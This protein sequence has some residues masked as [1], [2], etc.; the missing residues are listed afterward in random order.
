MK[1]KKILSVVLTLALVFSAAPL[2]GFVGLELPGLASLFETKAAAYGESGT[3][4]D[5]TWQWVTVSGR[6][7][8]LGFSGSGA[9]ADYASAADTP[10][11][12]YLNE[13]PFSSRILVSLSRQS[14]VTHIGD[15]AFAD[16][17]KPIS[18][19]GLPSSLTSIGDYAF[20]GSTLT[21]TL[22]IPT[23]VTSIGAWY[24]DASNPPAAIAVYY[25]GTPRDWAMI[26]MPAGTRAYLNQNLTTAASET[27]IWG[28]LY[29]EVGIDGEI[30]ITDCNTT[31]TS[32]VVPDEIDGL[33][34][35]AIDAGVFDFAGLQSVT[36][37][38]R[39]KTL[40][41]W[42]ADYSNAPA[43]SV[44]Y[45]NTLRAWEDVTKSQETHDYLQDVCNMTYAPNNIT[46]APL[47]Y[48]TERYET[49]E[50][51]ECASN[52]TG[53][54]SIPATVNGMPVTAIVERAFYDSLVTTVNIPAS[55]TEIDPFAGPDLIH[56][57]VDP[58]NPVYYSVNDC[59]VE[60]A[61]GKVVAGCTFSAL[62]DDGSISS[63]G[64]VA[65]YNLPD[66][67]LSV[68][69]D[70]VT[71]IEPGAFMQCTNLSYFYLPGSM[72][73][74]GDAAFALTSITDLYFPEN[75][76][77]IGDGVLYGDTALTEVV[78][79]VGVQSIG[80]W[81]DDYTNPEP[82]AIHVTYY[83]SASKWA[84]IQMSQATRDYLEQDITFLGYDAGDVIEY[85][86]YPQ[87]LVRDTNLINAL[88]EIDP[89]DGNWT[90]LGYYAAGPAGAMTPTDAMRYTDVTYQGEMYRGVIFNAY[91]DSNTWEDSGDNF[92]VPHELALNTVYWFKYEPLRWR[93]LDPNEGLVICESIIDVRAYND[94]L[95]MDRYWYYGDAAKTY[96]AS[97]YAESSIRAW[98]IDDF[99]NTAFNAAEQSNM[100]AA[101]L[102]NDCSMT[103]SGSDNF[104]EFDVPATNDKVF[105]LDFKTVNDGANSYLAGGGAV[106]HGTDYA[107]AQGLIYDENSLSSYWWLRTPGINDGQDASWVD[108]NGHADIYLTV[109]SACTG[110]RPVIKLEEIV[111]ERLDN[112]TYGP[113]TYS[114][115]LMSGLWV[116][117]CDPTYQGA[118]VIPT[119]ED[120]GVP[121]IGIDTGAFRNCTGV[122]SVTI[123][124]TV[125]VIG[126]NAFNSCYALQS[127]NIPASVSSFGESAFE[128]CIALSTV[129][130]ESGLRSIGRCAFM[131][132][133][134][135]TSLTIPASVTRI[136]D[137]AFAGTGLTAITL[138]S[139]LLSLGAAAFQNCRSL[140]GVTFECS[141]TLIDS[142]AFKNCTSLTAITLPD[143]LT[144]IGVQAF[145]GAG[146]TALTIPTG[147]ISI[148]EWYS[149]NTAPASIRVTYGGTQAQWDAITMSQKTRNYLGLIFNVINVFPLVYKGNAATGLTVIACSPVYSGALVVP[150]EPVAGMSV[151]AIGANA[152][153]DCAD[154]TRVTLPATV[155]EIGES[156][157]RNCTGMEEINIPAGVTEIGESA[158]RNCT[159]L[160]EI[161]IPAGVTVISEYAFMS[162]TEL[163]EITVPAG[164]ATIG[165]SAFWGCL[166]VTDLTIENGVGEIG[167]YAFYACSSLTDV[168]IPGSVLSV[169]NYAFAEC[170]NLESATFENGVVSLGS[171][172]FIY[173]FDLQTV[174]I[175]AS[176]TVI[177]EW[178]SEGGTVPSSITTVYG[179][180]QAQW[181]AITMSNRTRTY[182]QDL[183]TVTFVDQINHL[184][185]S[186]TA[187]VSVTLPEPD[188]DFI[189]ENMIFRGWST[190]ESG[191]TIYPIGETIRLDT[192]RTFY[193]K[194]V[195]YTLIGDNVPYNGGI[196]TLN[197]A[198]WLVVG[199]GESSWLLVSRDCLREPN[200]DMVSCNWDNAMSACDNVYTNSIAAVE[201]PLV[202]ATSKNADS[203]NYDGGMLCT[204]LELIDAHT[205]MLSAAEVDTYL[206]DETLPVLTE[207]KIWTRSSYQD[208]AL[209]GTNIF[210]EYTLRSQTDNGGVRP[211]LQLDRSMVLLTS[212]D[213][214]DSKVPAVDG[215]FHSFSVTP[216]VPQKLTIIRNEWRNFTASA[217]KSTVR[218]G[219]SLEITYG[220]NQPGTQVVISAMICDEEN[221]ILYYAST[222]KPTSS[223]TGGTWDLT[224][225]AELAAGNYTLKVFYERLIGSHGSDYASPAVELP[226]A[227]EPTIVVGG[228]SLT[229]DGDIGMNFYVDIPDVTANAYAEFTVAGETRTVP[230]NLSK[231]ITQNG[232]RLYK[233]SC[234]VHSVQTSMKIS[235]IFRNGDNSSGKILY[236]VNDYFDL[237][238]ATPSAQTNAKLMALMRSLAVYSYYANVQLEY[239]DDFIQS[240]LFDDSP[241]AS[242]DAA[243]IANYAEQVSDTANGVQWYG[244]SLVL[245][246]ETAIKL[247]FR[248]RSGQSIN[249]FTFTLSNGATS[250]VVT[251]EANGNLYVIEIPDIASGRLGTVYTVN[252][253]KNA[254]GSTV[255]TWSY[256]ALSY[257][258]KVLA[259]FESATP[260]VT[261]AQAN[262][263]KALVNYYNAAK[264]YFG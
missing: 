80:E 163:Q 81:L 172:I 103:L 213:C 210:G 253:T 130:M 236:A 118:I 65:F 42:R 190:A 132:C 245:R 66:L 119:A 195:Y 242:I 214:F 187:F 143:S 180:T 34:V 228:R 41:E 155:T 126:E 212:D 77:E 90:S 191:G 89:H 170:D 160:E 5:L 54:V 9:M 173:C 133:T 182:L 75:V 168:T 53:T 88:N 238:A 24:S 226:L 117:G 215:G 84:E 184:T 55:V 1:I 28:D 128:D 205:F 197:G 234:R 139:G 64:I 22:T 177:D 166:N 162:C 115:N 58:A 222:E 200:G 68:L 70:G 107:A 78:F 137:Y 116:V 61:T 254:D 183:H 74:V 192:D 59:V 40:G 219:E 186:I 248:L 141:L 250:N 153:K 122:T 108:F 47:T 235:A 109:T 67:I 185:Y 17:P 26:D 111:N 93:V 257:A 100:L 198:E 147:V 167:N 152:F 85:G 120:L 49:A 18:L 151:V 44:Y 124:S 73:K 11:A 39:L 217:D 16:F 241:L 46:V 69:P 97:N 208:H 249:D 263:A 216:G 233:F 121:V 135:L 63:I 161:N 223:A 125:T 99:Y 91:R 27:Y 251:P 29:Y 76:R 36:L 145:E 262:T 196:I 225:P 131:G 72:V 176:V 204:G 258:Y 92:N 146:L 38:R 33:P 261:Q 101:A 71:E 25:A 62:P 79:D 83:G 19:D 260:T 15:Y 37:P 114:G 23:S 43:V 165:K 229:L 140:S 218:P 144:H 256:A 255:N 87:S 169:G 201:Q 220:R 193:A 95:S 10:Y 203:Y 2:A 3:S 52:A 159:E 14:A 194:W 35:T 154:V 174:A 104:H 13:S 56:I 202:L 237:V 32:V 244:A 134:S 31:A 206:M 175:P 209:A 189:P 110:V 105:L 123:P 7:P 149:G 142:Y 102:N 136:E 30:T 207:N 157:F 150:A 156:A 57:N 82:A 164:V 199:Q 188:P 243:S 48:Y 231:Y 6:G 221:N 181:D 227:V 230:V 158:F 8:T 12:A 129:T 96:L 60:T 246:T 232:V 45:N 113:L 178:Y 98:L 112:Y 94:Y 247:Y 127:V 138:P 252:V 211:A 20:D 4:G 240:A 179:G 224:I 51:L 21:G 171:E 264:A 259:N 86:R 239:D 148:G 50:V 106:A